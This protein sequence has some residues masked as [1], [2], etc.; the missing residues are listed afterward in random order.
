[1]RR[2]SN[3]LPAAP[4]RRALLLALLIVAALSAL[5]IGQYARPVPSLAA[6]P[7]LAPT[8]S[9]PGA[10][11]VLPW[12]G[13][14][15]AAVAVHGLGV[16][17]TAGEP[18]ARP[19]GST[20]KIMTALLVLE[21]HPLQPGEAGPLVTVTA[22]DVV[23]YQVA[24]KDGQSVVP[25]SVGEQL[26]E[27]QLLQGL[28]LPSGNNLAQLLAR[29][30]VGTEAAFVEKLNAR[31]ATMGLRQTH[32]ADASGY[33]P[34]T[35]STPSEL[36]TMA[37][38]ALAQPI[39]AQIVAQPEVALPTVGTVYNV[40]AVLGQAGIVGVK[41]GSTP[42]AGS[43]FVFAARNTVEG[44]PVTIIGAVM[45][46]AQLSES[47]SAATLLTAAVT[48]GLQMAR[49]IA[50]A[51]SVAAFRPPWGSQVPI[52]A[53]EEITLLGWPGLPTQTSLV[54]PAVQAPLAD[55]ASVGTLTFQAGEFSR[56]IPLHIAQPL[57][58]PPLD[59]RLRRDLLPN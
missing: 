57:P 7:L 17:G 20:A 41:T 1:V 39:F 54:I 37:Q 16:L 11:P 15:A 3:P 45:G 38:V 42:E 47:F 4:W 22:Q 33:A 32:F 53:D 12:P 44:Q 26:S 55:G 52:V 13:T 40:N 58:A 5:A 50:R 31:A 14:G 9:L 6:E 24:V 28:L 34:R 25:V 56:E 36:I 29:W 30:D 10:A 43:C 21:D 23:D 18:T 51:Q 19:T 35:V 59:W 27:Y 8:A 48:A 49:P 2:S 46:Q